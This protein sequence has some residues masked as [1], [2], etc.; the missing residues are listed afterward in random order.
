MCAECTEMMHLVNNNVTEGTV[1][2]T[3]VQIA[4][5]KHFISMLQTNTA[6]TT[7]ITQCVC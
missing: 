3:E 7:N 1:V 5:I 4:P 2:E 6:R